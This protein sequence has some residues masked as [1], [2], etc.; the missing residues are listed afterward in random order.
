MAIC[1]YL[2]SPRAAEVDARLGWG[3]RGIFNPSGTRAPALGCDATKRGAW[4]PEVDHRSVVNLWQL[5]GI[6]LGCKA[7]EKGH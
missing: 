5:S 7:W 1:A 4:L 6:P 3:Y 2:F